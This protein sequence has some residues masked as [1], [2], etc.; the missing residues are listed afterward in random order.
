MVFLLS[1]FLGHFQAVSSLR[2]FL[3][4]E[5]Q[6]LLLFPIR[7]QKTVGPKNTIHPCANQMFF[8][9]IFHVKR[10]V[11]I[12]ETLEK[13]KM[14]LYFFKEQGHNLSKSCGGKPLH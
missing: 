4:V 5:N 6:I 8:K 14:K 10:V 9:T 13:T 1:K 2:K 7:H 3:K 12:S 11:T